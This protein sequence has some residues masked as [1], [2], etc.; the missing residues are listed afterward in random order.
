[1]RVWPALTQPHVQVQ[2]RCLL[3]WGSASLMSETQK[4]LHGQEG[5]TEK[6][7]APAARCRPL[8]ARWPQI[9]PS[10]RCPLH[11][12]LCPPGKGSTLGGIGGRIQP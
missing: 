4:G 3:L 2:P 6:G 9:V 5:S 11:P 10:W 8:G 12:Q 1:M 7:A